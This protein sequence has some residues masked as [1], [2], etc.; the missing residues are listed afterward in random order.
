VIGKYGYFAAAILV[1]LLIHPYPE[2]WLLASM[3][4]GLSDALMVAGIIGLGIEVSAAE[5]LIKHA[6]DELSERLVGYGLPD[7][8][9]K[10]ISGIVRE[11]RVYRNYR[12]SYQLSLHQSGKVFIT[13]RT[14]YTVVNNG[15]ETD[16]NYRP[17]MEEEG[18]YEPHFKSLRYRHIYIDDESQVRAFNQTT[19][20]VKFAPP[21]EVVD[22]EPSRALDS[23]ESLDADQKCEVLW[24]T[25][26][27]MQE[28]Y[29]DVISFGGV[30]VK[31]TIELLSKPENFEFEAVDNPDGVNKCEHAQGSST[32]VYNRA[33]VRAQ[34]VRVWWRPRQFAPNAVPTGGIGK[35]IP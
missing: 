17:T 4:H 21:T 23:L 19:H 7:D 16:R 25:T 12:R 22:I 15:K 28:D 14:A 2:G 5:V 6:A 1:G 27:V 13:A 10:V 35:L 34:H 26:L 11:T 24:V 18:M 30:T 33:F 3:A 20:V 9:Q 8:A 31:P 29:S 32:W